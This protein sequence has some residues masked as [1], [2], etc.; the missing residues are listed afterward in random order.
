MNVLSDESAH[1]AEATDRLVESTF[2]GCITCRTEGESSCVVS[3][4]ALSLT[5]GDHAQFALVR[6]VLRQGV[7][8]DF[9]EAVDH[10][11]Q[12]VEVVRHAAASWPMAS[13]RWECASLLSRLL[14]WVRS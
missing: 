11:E 5:H 14:I 9:R 4:A 13:R 10:L 6:A 12:V 2:A 7:A 1:A 3:A 8:G